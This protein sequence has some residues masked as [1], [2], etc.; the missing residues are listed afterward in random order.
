MR[1]KRYEEAIAAYEKALPAYVG[2]EPTTI[3][4]NLAYCYLAVSREDK[5]IEVMRMFYGDASKAYIEETI[6]RFKAVLK[7]Q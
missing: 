7:K 2:G 5:A 1:M 3:A 4:G 6:R